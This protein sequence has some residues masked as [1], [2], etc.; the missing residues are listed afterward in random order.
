MTIP[1]ILFYGDSRAADWSIPALSGVRF[2][3]RGIPGDSTAG[4]LRRFP[5]DAAA[6]APDVIVLQLGVNDLTGAIYA[7]PHRA[8]EIITE[9]QS[10]L[11]QIVARALDLGATLILT[12]IFPPAADGWT[13]WSHDHA[14]LAEAIEQ[15]NADLRQLTSERVILLE[16]APLLAEQ[17]R[18]KPDFALDTL[19]LNQAG[20]AALNTALGP[21]LAEMHP[22]GQAL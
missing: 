21:M 14:A 13:G 7:P 17:G 9:C 1:T 11:R 12:T 18:V 16:T 8:A 20:Y 19:H 6:L 3:N 10:N 22:F 2:A 5:H 15:V 4:A